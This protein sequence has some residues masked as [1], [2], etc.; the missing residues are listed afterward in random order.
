MNTIDREWKNTVDKMVDVS[1]SSVETS[2]RVLSS[3]ECQ[4]ATI[5]YLCT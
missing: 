4:L 1:K 2:I 3:F 5:A